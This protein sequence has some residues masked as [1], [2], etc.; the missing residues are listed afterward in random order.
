MSLR[1]VPS[2]CRL[3]PWDPNTFCDV[4]GNR[5]LLFVGD[6]AM[7]EV[8]A[9]VMNHVA[10]DGA[11][12]RV[13]QRCASRIFYGSSDT[14]IGQHLGGKFN[15]G[16]HWMKWID[17]IQ[18]DI[19]VMNAHAHV[20]GP[21]NFSYVVNTVLEDIR[22]NLPPHVRILWMTSIP[23]GCG[24]APLTAL[25]TYGVA[26]W[27]TPRNATSLPYN[28]G[29]FLEREPVVQRML[30]DS[31]LAAIEYMNLLPLHYRVDAHVSTDGH[32]DCLHMCVPG[33][34]SLIPQVL[35]HT[36]RSDCDR[37]Q[38]REQRFARC[39]GSSAAPRRTSRSEG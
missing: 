7:L 34:L 30:R 11:A 20:F 14:L 28:W 16:H 12:C 22:R 3:R 17:E 38:R 24:P 18:P 19:V 1:W 23:G 27:T 32:G 21:A 29:E 6:S 36:L 5:T 2:Q 15:R 35:L 9:V 10:W 31:S 4:L 39:S 25:P 37:N 8:A 26:S 13:Q 33:P